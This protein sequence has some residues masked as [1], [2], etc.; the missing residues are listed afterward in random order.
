[1]SAYD[2]EGARRERLRTAERRVAAL[3]AQRCRLERIV[4][5]LLR[6][7]E[8]ETGV[9]ALVLLAAAEDLDREAVA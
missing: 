2:A 8:R 6:A 1:V 7:L 3:D 5:A 9:G 4:A